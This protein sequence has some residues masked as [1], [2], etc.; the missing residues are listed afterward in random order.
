MKIVIGHL[1]GMLPFMLLVLP[2]YLY[3][4]PIVLS[5]RGLKANWKHETALCLFVVFAVGLASQTVLPDIAFTG[6]G[7]DFDMNGEHN[8]ALIPFRI[9]CYLY[10]DL[11][12][13]HLI[14]SLLIDYLGNILMFVPIGFCV[15]LLWRTSDSKTIAAGFITSLT[16]EIIQLFL[17]RWT[18][19]DDLILN[20]TG[21]AVG[22]LLYKMLDM[23]HSEFLSRFRINKNGVNRMNRKRNIIALIIAMAAGF[24][25]AMAA[26]AAVIYFGYT[27]AYASGTESL[28]VSLYGLD[29]YTLTKEG[30][31]YTGAS[32]GQ[33]MGI[34]CAAYVAVT[35]LIEQIIIRAADKK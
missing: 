5:V 28:N 7:I 17:P 6:N 15:P 16:I 4:R 23:R 20:T 31:A 22:L 3:F 35:V 1:S 10:R 9:F 33:N 24:G 14:Y 27:D 32:V 19:I 2:V 34:I 8:T 11:F 26:M 30:A 25:L 12:E 13:Y 29:I 18:D 21:T